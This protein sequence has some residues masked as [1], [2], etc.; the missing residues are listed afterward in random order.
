M[1]ESI[2][3]D[4]DRLHDAQD[5]EEAREERIDALVPEIAARLAKDVTLAGDALIELAW[6][7]IAALLRDLAGFAIRRDQDLL[8]ALCKQV[9]SHIEAAAKSQAES[10]ARDEVARLERLGRDDELEARAA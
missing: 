8:D 10:D 3:R 6:E 5:A 2:L 4:L 7:P 9:V 1:S